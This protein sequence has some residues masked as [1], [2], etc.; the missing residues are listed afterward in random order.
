MLLPFPQKTTNT[1]NDTFVIP[2]IIEVL[3]VAI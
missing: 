1:G 2:F 3:K